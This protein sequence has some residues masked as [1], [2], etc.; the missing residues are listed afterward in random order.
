MGSKLQ[1]TKLTHSVVEAKSLIEKVRE[2]VQ[3]IE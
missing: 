3:N 1:M 2:Q